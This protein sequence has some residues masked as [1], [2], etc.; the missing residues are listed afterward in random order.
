[1]LHGNDTQNLDLGIGLVMSLNLNIVLNFLT[2]VNQ[3]AVI[4][5]KVTVL[6]PMFDCEELPAEADVLGNPMAGNSHDQWEG[7][8]LLSMLRLLQKKRT[9]SDL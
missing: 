9:G 2:V 1:M 5:H 3:D 4:H 7:S 8:L 6:S